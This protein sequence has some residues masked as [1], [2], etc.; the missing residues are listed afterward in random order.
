MTSCAVDGDAFIVEVAP[1]LHVLRRTAL[2]LTG[3]EQAAD[4]LLQD[5]LERTFVKFGRYRCGTNIRAW[6][7]RI[8][9]NIRINGFRGHARRPQAWSLEA[10]DECSP[11]R[12]V[13]QTG[14]ALTDV[15]SVILSRLGEEAIRQAI[16]ALPED[17]RMVVFLADVEELAYKDIAT[18]L[19]V[20]LGTVSSRLFRGRRLLQ[21]ALRT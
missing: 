2:R 6:L 4:D 16:D 3:H 11:Y 21:R 14:V 12:A 17:I 7:L 9:S 8:M 15:E 1:H 13:R 20:P 19:S 18:I 10:L 5:T